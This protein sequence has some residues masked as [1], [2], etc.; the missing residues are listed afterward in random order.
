MSPHL[1]STIQISGQNGGGQILRS[2]LSLSMITG[3]PFR[4]THIRGKRSKPGLMRQHLTCVKAAA[5]IS[6]GSVDG[7]ELGSTEIIFHPGEI[8][9]GDYHFA[10]GTAG[11]TTLLAQTLLPALWKAEGETKLTLEGGTHNPL[12]PPMDFLTRVYLPMLGKMGITIDGK[13]ERY[14]FSPAGGG[15]IVFSIPGNQTP[16]QLE[17][18][19]RGE[20]VGRRIHAL[21]ALLRSEILEKESKALCKSLDWPENIQWQ[22]ATE[23]SDC[24]G[25]VL[26][27][28]VEFTNVIERAS[29][30]GAFGKR[31]SKVAHE[32]STMMQNYLGSGAPVGRCL[33]DQLLLPMALAGGGTF[34]TMSP[35]NHVV[36]NAAVIEKFLPVK[37]IDKDADGLAMV[38]LVS[39]E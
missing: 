20:E 4:L 36:T 15:K 27:A 14:G 28:E 32:V 35:S 11:S 31:S 39:R 33:A 10:I 7:A 16:T 37:C 8:A 23:N 21:G 12:A 5:E 25:N 26:A 30:F 19:E 34:K 1:T 13:L 18:L 22:E 38:A 29:S 17:L 3:Q 9:A 24:S 2:A 6:N